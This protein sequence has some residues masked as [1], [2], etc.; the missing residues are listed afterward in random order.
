MMGSQQTSKAGYPSWYHDTYSVK[1]DQAAEA[2]WPCLA[3]P[4]STSPISPSPNPNQDP[5]IPR[6]RITL[7]N[8]IV[9]RDSTHAHGN[10]QERQSVS[11][12]FGS[13][14]VMRDEEWGHNGLIHKMIPG[15][16]FAMFL[17]IIGLVSVM[18]LFWCSR[19]HTG[20]CSQC[21]FYCY[22]LSQY[23]LTLAFPMMI[24]LFWILLRMAGNGGIMKLELRKKVIAMLICFASWT[25][26]LC[27]F[28]YAIPLISEPWTDTRHGG[29]FSPWATG[30]VPLSPRGCES[31][32]GKQQSSLF[33]EDI[34]RVQFLRVFDFSDPSDPPNFSCPK[35]GLGEFLNISSNQ[36]LCDQGFEGNSDLYGLGVRFGIYI[37]WIASILSNNF[38]SESRKEFQK[39]YLIFSL[40]ICTA[41]F[42]SS[43]DEAC[44]FGIEIEILY[45]FYWGGSLC[46]FAFSPNEVPLGDHAQWIGLEWHRAIQYLTH[47]MMA[48]HGIFYCF[49]GYDQFF[50]RMPCGT[51][52]FFFAPVL[53][54]SKSFCDL[55]DIFS[56]LIMP[57][58]PPLVPLV[59]TVGFL[60]IPE[61]NTA[62][63]DSV[64]YRLFF[65]DYDQLQTAE[66]NASDDPLKL[67]SRIFAQMRQFRH[68]IKLVYRRMRQRCHL[69]P[70]GERGIRLVTPI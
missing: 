22:R 24:F 33:A 4:R 57:L 27:I 36:E 69:P 40:A 13:P 35:F 28:Y 30:P 32:V 17:S 58:L 38:L 55:R 29:S 37:Q 66:S 60:L 8:N 65:S 50:A 53:D 39:F 5:D 54:P 41:T 15:V 52:H 12:E 1:T 10:A 26:F 23:F 44:I 67:S 68:R 7:P 19:I 62:I 59:P 21:Y 70:H 42:V 48:Y 2:L 11:L 43:F 9:A 16:Y 56:I 20:T 25:F 34:Y 49:Y 46:V 63:R 51:Y 64:V 31:R 47:I 18:I 3:S 45:W 61:I 14:P 6:R